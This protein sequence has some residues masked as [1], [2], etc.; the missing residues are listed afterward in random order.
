MSSH[1]KLP[2]YVFEEI[3]LKRKEM[4]WV[5]PSGDV[6]KCFLYRDVLHWDNIDVSLIHHKEKALESMKT[7]KYP[8]KKLSL[9]VVTVNDNIV[10]HISGL[11]SEL[12]SL[13]LSYIRGL[14]YYL[15]FCNQSFIRIIVHLNLIYPLL[16]F[17]TKFSNERFPKLQR[18]VLRRNLNPLGKSHH[19]NILSLDFGHHSEVLREVRVENE[20][21]DISFINSL[22][23]LA[24]L[25]SLSVS[26][27]TFQPQQREMFFTELGALTTL[28]SLF[29]NF[30]LI[31]QIIL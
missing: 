22:K 16:R 31:K 29:N 1:V 10:E 26:R 25:T 30:L 23:S 7:V 5:I 18:L 11:G 15:D 8:V 21:I 6:E 13:E 28:R 19:K 24:N 17:I 27:C 20:I 2:L 12:T 9:F 14:F 3:L 4:G